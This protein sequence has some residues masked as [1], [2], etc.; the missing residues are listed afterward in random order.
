MSQCQVSPLRVLPGGDGAVKTGTQNCG[1]GDGTVP[2]C[3]T[4]RATVSPSHGGVRAGDGEGCGSSEWLPPCSGYLQQARAERVVLE[5]R[6]HFLPPQP[7]PRCG[8]GRELLA[9]GI[10][11]TAA[12]ESSKT[13]PGARGSR[14]GS[15][16][17]GLCSWD[18]VIFSPSSLSTA[19]IWKQISTEKAPVRKSNK[20]QITLQAAPSCHRS[21]GRRGA[22]HSSSASQNPL[23][24]ASPRGPAWL[25]PS[26][27]LSTSLCPLP[28]QPEQQ[29]QSFV[30]SSHCCQG[31]GWEKLPQP[32]RDSVLPRSFHL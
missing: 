11:H 18:G 15:I 17:P 13:S 5:R 23:P 28:C 8:D 10:S 22:P 24:P 27:A 26:T 32:S 16:P 12:A 3:C 6:Y 1:S 21:R 4:Q 9:L 2:G 31:R 30:F 25:T 19:L 14:L 29:E 20:S 7:R